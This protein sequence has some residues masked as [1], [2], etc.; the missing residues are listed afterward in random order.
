M[1]PPRQIT[2]GSS[3]GLWVALLPYRASGPV[4]ISPDQVKAW[5]DTRAGANSQ[6]APRWTP[7]PAP[8]DGKWTAT[9]TFDE[10]GS[11]VLR[12]HASDGALWADRDIKVTVTR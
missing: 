5:E 10:P 7:P 11:Y 9:V 6:W 12:W 3:T 1:I 2:V 8:P 4:H